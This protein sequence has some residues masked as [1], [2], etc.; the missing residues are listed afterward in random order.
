M[1]HTDSFWQYRTVTVTTKKYR[2]DEHYPKPWICVMPILGMA[3]LGDTAEE[4]FTEMTN[5][6]QK[7]LDEIN[8]KPFPDIYVPSCN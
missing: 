4:A 8:T 6:F 2:P 7:I 5:V 3:M 1:A